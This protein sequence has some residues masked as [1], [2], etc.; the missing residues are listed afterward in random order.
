M[1]SSSHALRRRAQS[2]AREAKRK[3][4]ISSSSTMGPA[5]W[6][7][8]ALAGMAAAAWLYFGPEIIRYMRVRRM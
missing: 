8:L 1:V 3:A 2:I 5:A 4:G 6:T 7:G